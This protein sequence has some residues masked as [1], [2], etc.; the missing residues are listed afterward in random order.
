MALL[1]YHNSPHSKIL[2]NVAKYRSIEI[3]FQNSQRS[4]TH[5]FHI[6]GALGF[7]QFWPLG[8]AIYV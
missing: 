6:E 7:G 2:Q 8:F 4:I 5:T 3:L 1:L